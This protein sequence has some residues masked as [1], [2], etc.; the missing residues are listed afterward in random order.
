M[1]ALP[2]HLITVRLRE[3]RIA[4]P[5]WTTDLIV[6]LEKHISFAQFI[7][8]LAFTVASVSVAFAS[9]LFSYRQHFGW[10]PILLVSGHGIGAITVNNS[11][12]S[13]AFLDF[14]FWNRH[15]YPI[16]IGYI[17]V[18]FR[19]LPNDDAKA[20]ELNDTTFWTNA[21][22]GN[23]HNRERKV[24]K[25]GEQLRYALQAPLSPPQAVVVPALN[26]MDE[27]AKVEIGYFD[28]RRNK[29]R[30]L[31]RFHSFSFKSKK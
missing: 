18:H 28:P 5:Q 3:K 17:E 14:E 2:K 24:V 30:V 4:L 9:L 16:V 6:V 15:S 29:Y 8:Y 20:K 25:N 13:Y 7:A 31:T 1:K 27:T 10:S 11:S 12:K 19:G 22:K 23:F 21:G 26:K